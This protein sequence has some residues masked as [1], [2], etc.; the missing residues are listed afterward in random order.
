MLWTVFCKSMDLIA[1]D[2]KSDSSLGSSER[3][4]S[5]I[6]QT[7]RQ[8][9]TLRRPSAV[10]DTAINSGDGIQRQPQ[11]TKGEDLESND[12]VDVGSAKQESMEK[13]ADTDSTIITSDATT[14]DDNWV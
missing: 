4:D 9:S 8:A 3:R 1:G 5:T 12:V 13:A 11:P 7:W 6:V 2:I 10:S 14:A